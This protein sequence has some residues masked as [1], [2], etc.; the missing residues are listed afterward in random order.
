MLNGSLEVQPE[1]TEAFELFEGVAVPI[2]YPQLN[3]V[4]GL[5]KGGFDFVHQVWIK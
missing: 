1:P 5:H 3:V 4:E 2:L